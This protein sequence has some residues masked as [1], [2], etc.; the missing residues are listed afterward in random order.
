[1]QNKK[2]SEIAKKFSK[3]EEERQQKLSSHHE[4]MSLLADLLNH[5]I[6]EAYLHYEIRFYVFDMN[7]DTDPPTIHVGLVGCCKHNKKV[8]TKMRQG[9]EKKLKEQTK[10]KNVIWEL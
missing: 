1:M 6:K 3:T 9:F 8:P 4:E 5:D 2:F 10:F 7:L